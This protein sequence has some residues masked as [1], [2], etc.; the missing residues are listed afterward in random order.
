[1]MHR[2][3]LLFPLVT[4]FAAQAQTTAVAGTTPSLTQPVILG[5]T[6][7]T[8]KPGKTADL[9]H[10]REE[11]MKSMDVPGQ[12]IT[13]GLSSVTGKEEVLYLHFY[14]SMGMIEDSEKRVEAVGEQTKMNRLNEREGDL[15]IE[16]RDL[17]L[18]RMPDL[19][20]H[21]DVDWAQTEYLDLIT[22]HVRPGHH[23]EYLEL[24]KT[25]LAGHVRGGIN[26]NLIVFKTTSG[27]P[28]PLYFILRPIKS[29]HTHD[30]LRAKG[31]GEPLTDEENSKMIKLLGAAVES[32][33]EEFF[34]VEPRISSVTPAWA[35]SNVAFW[36]GPR[37]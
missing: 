30:E 22:I 31:F 25:A 23:L 4:C 8:V 37:P 28:S 15:L 9:V 26:T 5:M 24:R 6:R 11:A 3:G 10:L 20:Y 35:A 19:T 14:D 34:R 1:M 17:T 29:L 36:E 7:E 13:I 27:A 16:K 18:L 33:E 21:P 2:F 12:P 32:E